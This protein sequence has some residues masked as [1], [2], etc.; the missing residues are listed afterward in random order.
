[1]WNNVTDLR[2]FYA[3]PLGRLV[4]QAILRRLREMWP[5]AKGQ[6]VLGFG[7]ATPYLR[8]FVAGA[9]RTIALVPTEQETHC[10]PAEG[11]N[12]LGMVEETCL[13]LPDLSFDRV[14]LVHAV[15]SSEALRAML[16]E[17]WRVMKDGGSLMV[18]AAHRRSL[19]ARLEHT[20]FGHGRPFSTTQINRLLHDALFEPVRSKPALF[21]PP[22][23]SRMLLGTARAWERIGPRALPMFAGV[24]LTEATKVIYAGNAV[25][26]GVKAKAAPV[27]V[28][29]ASR[30]QIRGA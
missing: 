11:P 18:V 22:F 14:L 4:Q 23:R 6:S 16:R 29:G 17:V 12:V 20:P 3:T 13:P 19:W 7:Y 26:K 1:M 27:R 25:A 9:E 28:V 2:D 8:P 30:E 21:L 24:T 5:E 15:E 10:W